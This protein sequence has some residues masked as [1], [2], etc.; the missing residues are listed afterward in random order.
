L[1]RVVPNLSSVVRPSK[2]PGTTC[3]FAPENSPVVDADCHLLTLCTFGG[4]YFG[5]GGLGRHQI[6]FFAAILRPPNRRHVVLRFRAVGRLRYT[7]SPCPPPSNGALAMGSLVWRPPKP[8]S[9]PTSF[10]SDLVRPRTASPLRWYA[11]SSRSWRSLSVAFYLSV[12]WP[13]K[14]LPRKRLGWRCFYF[15]I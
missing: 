4:Q 14:G 10:P 11:S 2:F 9:S 1:L 15:R 7:P 5:S 3:T 12:V 6:L 8:S 13:T